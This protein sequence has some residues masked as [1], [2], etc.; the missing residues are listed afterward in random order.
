M[1]VINEKAVISKYIKPRG[2]FTAIYDLKERSKIIDVIAHAEKFLNLS[3]TAFADFIHI[4]ALL[5]IYFIYYREGTVKREPFAYFAE[6]AVTIRV[7]RED[8]TPRLQEFDLSS[9]EF[10]VNIRGVKAKYDIDMDCKCVSV[11][12]EAEVIANLV[13]ERTIILRE[14]P[15]INSEEEMEEF[16]E[17]PLSSVALSKNY[18]GGDLRNYA[19]TLEELSKAINHKLI[20][21]EEEKKG[22]KKEIERMQDEI[23]GKDERYM[24]LKEKLINVSKDYT[25]QM[26]KIKSIETKYLREQ[27]KAQLLE[28]ESNKRLEE[29]NQLSREKE[30]MLFN[31]ESH[32]S[33]I[34]D[35]IKQLLNKKH[36]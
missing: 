22:L 15:E 12:I 2:I 10:A 14:E 24:S 28:Q 11:E 3:C 35:R 25:K 17:I 5:G 30:K 32:K 8:F 9:G 21:I 29:I 36:G 31:I 18:F 27:R 6:E 13:E 26:D 33:T 7:N 23:R 19:I 4:K 1:P 16:D 20:E 34:K